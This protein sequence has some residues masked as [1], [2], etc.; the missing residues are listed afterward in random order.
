MNLYVSA[1]EKAQLIRV[2]LMQDILSDAIDVYAGLDS[3]DKTFLAEMRHGRTRIEKAIKFRRAALDK[4]ADD[5]L[6]VS[7]GKLHPMFLP[8]PEAKKAHKELFEIQKVLP[9]DI[10]DL[11]DWYGFAIESTCKN[12]TKSDYAECPARRVL[13][14]YEICPIDPGAK[15]KC[16]YSYVGTPEAEELQ[17]VDT[18]KTVPALVYNAALAMA[19]AKEDSIIENYVPAIKQLQAEVEELNKEISAAKKQIED[20]QEKNAEYIERN[21]ELYA[22][23][24]EYEKLKSEFVEKVM[25]LFAEILKQEIEAKRESETSV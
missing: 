20:L 8:T 12:C 25:P 22:E 23:I 14:K 11:Q 18:D 9:I 19:R 1:N 6:T 21:Q 24:R 3:T 13:S 10:E 7:V 16:Q 17:P 4:E 15:D 5:K 2:I